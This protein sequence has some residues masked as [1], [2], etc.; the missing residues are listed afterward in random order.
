[1]VEKVE[2]DPFDMSDPLTRELAPSATRE[3]MW[4]FMSRDRT[5][6]LTPMDMQ[7]QTRNLRSLCQRID[8]MLTGWDPKRVPFVEIMSRIDRAIQRHNIHTRG[9]RERGD[10]AAEERRL[11]G[12]KKRKLAAPRFGVERKVDDAA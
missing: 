8:F 10:Q 9:I 12:V 4:A 11:A 1:M 5:V 7:E 2:K 3:I 6:A